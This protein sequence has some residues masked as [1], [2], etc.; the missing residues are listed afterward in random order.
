M[1]GF[2]PRLLLLSV[3]GSIMGKFVLEGLALLIAGIMLRGSGLLAT[4]LLVLTI[5]G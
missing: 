1:E 3:A 2:D 5:V 4:W